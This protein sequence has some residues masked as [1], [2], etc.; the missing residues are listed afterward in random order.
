MAKNLISQD[1]RKLLLHDMPSDNKL[2]IPIDT[3]CGDAKSNKG[4][5]CWWHFIFYPHIGPEKNGLYHPMYSYEEE[6]LKGL[7][8]HRQLAVFKASKLGIT[9]FV[10]IWMLHQCFVNK[11][12]T[13]KDVMIVTGPNVELAKDLIA[14]AKQILL[15]RLLPFADQGAYGFS[16]NGVR[17][18]AYPSNNISA[19][20]GQPKVAMVFGDEAAFFGQKDDTDV[21]ETC[22]RY[23]GSD[24]GWLVFVST[25]GKEAAGFFYDILEDSQSPYHKIEMYYE[26]GLEKHPQ[27][28]TS[29]YQPEFIE[30]AMKLRSFEREY[31]GVW[32]ADSGDIFPQEPLDRCCK[33]EYDIFAENDSFDRVIGVDPG[34]G[35]SQYGIVAIQKQKGKYVTIHAESIERASYIDAINK[36][37]LVADRFK[38]NKVFV[39]SS[40]PE[41]I[42]DLRDK[43]GL[44]VTGIAF[45]AYGTKMLHFASDQVSTD[46]VMIHPM[47]KKLK[48]QL[49]AIKVN[50]RGL[51][52]KT[53]RNP[54]DIGDAF[55]LALWYYKIGSGY[56]GVF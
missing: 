22:E 53:D 10:I 6:F 42:L 40:A 24:G 2:L 32:A 14:R 35:S 26:R 15:N 43:M 37:R 52:D 16:V 25:A 13:G 30:E 41:L 8:E 50:K 54:F 11:F 49:M 23:V 1:T 56:V 27:T 31:C 17:V 19:M 38:I 55:L 21:I 20:R 9:E 45:N 5:C 18:K 34:Y 7:T 51:P 28:G 29:M 3:W 46:R 12:F 47:F 4:D 36:I 48:K 33:D 39:D 44:N